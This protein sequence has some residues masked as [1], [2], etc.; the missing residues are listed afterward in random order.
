M[1]RKPSMSLEELALIRDNVTL[2]SVGVLN[3]TDEA[4]KR[5]SAFA[6]DTKKSFM[7]KLNS[8][9]VYINPFG[10]KADMTPY[11]CYRTF[12]T[13]M[14]YPDVS[15]LTLQVPDGFQ[16]NLKDYTETIFDLLENF[17]ARFISDVL[18]PYDVYLGKI[19]NNPV[20]LQSQLQA[21][22]FSPKDIEKYKKQ[23]TKFVTSKKHNEAPLGKVYQRMKDIEDQEILLN[24]ISAYQSANPLMNVKTKVSEIGAKITILA[25]MFKDNK[26]NITASAKTFNELAELTYQLA[27]Q[28]EFYTVIETLINA[29]LWVSKENGEKFKRVMGGN[30]SVESLFNCA[31]YQ[32]VV[33]LSGYSLESI[34]NYIG[35]ETQPQ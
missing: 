17:S 21:H 26:L 18:T 3:V 24:R 23:L 28:V 6:L 35:I 19:I 33:E 14:K 20:I 31:S 13:T 34:V 5:F 4:F 12:A 2:E 27:E 22:K 10:K 8:I 9:T 25:N 32:G 30:A 1:A 29:L 7:D 16:G 11:A 15:K